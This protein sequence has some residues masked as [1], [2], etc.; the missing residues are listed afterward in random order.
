[1]DVPSNSI[2]NFINEQLVRWK[3]TK[4]KRDKNLEAHKPVITISS[5]PGSGGESQLA[6]GLARKL[7]FDLFKRDI[8][9]EISDSAHISAKIMETIG[10]DR[11]ADVSEHITKVIADRFLWP[12][13]YL[14]H[15]MKVIGIIGKHGNAVIVGRGV[16]FIIPPEERLSIRIVAPLNIRVQNTAR[17]LK[18]QHPDAQ[19]RVL[20]H[21][22]ERRAF[23]RKSF[24]ADASDPNNYDLVIN[25][26]GMNIESSINAISDFWTSDYNL[27]NKTWLPD[28]K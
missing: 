20:N 18:M 19:R 5:E 8:I 23:I 4:A 11:L 1:M 26:Q 17:A 22:S 12:D 15:L 3:E 2:E 9:K 10:K 16:N 14:E 28:G 13:L 7:E 25:T 21:E 24:N 27:K 6:P